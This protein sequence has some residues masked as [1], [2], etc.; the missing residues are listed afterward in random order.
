VIR[1]HGVLVGMTIDILAEGPHRPVDILFSGKRQ[2][3]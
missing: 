2:N 1:D 3:R